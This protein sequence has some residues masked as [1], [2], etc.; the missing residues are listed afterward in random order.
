MSPSLLA[1]ADFL[2]VH[3]WLAIALGI[4][5]ARRRVRW[6]AIG[7]ATAFYCSATSVLSAIVFTP[8]GYLVLMLGWVLVG[9]EP[10]EASR[11]VRPVG[12]ALLFLL[13]C[14]V[15]TGIAWLNHRRRMHS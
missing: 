1:F 3:L 7:I 14:G 8:S 13:F 2:Q 15:P 11:S 10:H 6:V 4:V 5:V 12:I 9:G